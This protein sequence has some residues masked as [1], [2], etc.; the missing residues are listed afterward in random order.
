MTAGDER[1]CV[2]MRHKPPPKNLREWSV[3]QVGCCGRVCVLIGSMRSL[4]FNTKSR[5]AKGK[6]II[7]DAH[8]DDSGGMWDYKMGF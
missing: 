4:I 2:G 1:C 8:E 5:I 6:S 7:H 3:D